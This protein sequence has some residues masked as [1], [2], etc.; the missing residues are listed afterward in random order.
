M[1]SRPFTPVTG[2]AVRAESGQADLA[3]EAR[4]AERVAEPADL[5]IEGRGPD[6]RVVDEPGRQV[7][8]ER[9]ERVRAPIGP[10]RREP[11]SR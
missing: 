1:V 11:S 8:D 2:L 3:D 6:V 9:L 5:V 7:L 4:V 10:G